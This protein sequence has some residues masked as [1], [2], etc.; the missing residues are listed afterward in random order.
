MDPL[1]RESSAYWRRAGDFRSLS[2][3]AKEKS[4]ALATHPNE[5]NLFLSLFLLNSP[6]FQRFAVRSNAMAQ[7]LA[8]KSTFRRREWLFLSG[9]S[10]FSKR[11]ATPQQPC[12]LF[13]SKLKKK[14]RCGAAGRALQDRDFFRRNLQAGGEKGPRRGREAAAAASKGRFVAAR[15]SREK[16][17]KKNS[18]SLCCVS[19]SPPLLRFLLKITCSA[20]L[21]INQNR[22][23]ESAACAL[24]LL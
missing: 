16:F 4:T 8:K 20:V 9:C 11:K 5:K 1:R 17:S 19:P 18:P 21:Y 2:S 14:N 22:I 13:P 3:S 6:T 15:E 23:L 12:S 10:A 7:E 24:V